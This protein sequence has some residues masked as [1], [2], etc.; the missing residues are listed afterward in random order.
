[1]NK[2]PIAAWLILVAS[3]SACNSGPDQRY[4]DATLGRSL[5][6]PPDLLRAESESKFELPAVF[7]GDDPSVRDKVPVLA[8]VESVRLEGSAG[9]YWLSVEEPVNTLYQMVKNFWAAEGYRLVVDEPVIGIMQTEWVLTEVGKKAGGESWWDSLFASDDL[10]ATQDQF[11]TRIERDQGRNRIYIVHRGTE[12]QHVLKSGD[13]YLPGESSDNKWRYRQPD[14]ELEIEMLSRLMI[15]LGL[16][17]SEV[18]QQISQARL[19]TPRASMHTDHEEKSPFLLLKDPYQI[20]WNRVYHQ[21]ERMNIKIDSASFKSG[22]SGEGVITVSAEVVEG[23]E[24]KGLFSFFSSDD[25]EPK[26]F[27]LI[28]SEESH[29]LTRVSIENAEGNLDTTSAGAQLL[30]LLYDQV[31]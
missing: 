26:I 9:L 24:D 11:R 18:E 3:L 6:L 12:Y 8:R 19:F 28:V 25:P 30:A 22:L 31:R 16:G 2:F 1:M 13:S 27:S 29:E 15:Y 17:Q 4:L 14:P 20:A 5:E 10:S 23:A 7:I 21:L